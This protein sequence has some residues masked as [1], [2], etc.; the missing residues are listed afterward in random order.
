MTAAAR[1]IQAGDRVA[2]AYFGG[3]ALPGCMPLE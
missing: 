1:A 3:A 2:P